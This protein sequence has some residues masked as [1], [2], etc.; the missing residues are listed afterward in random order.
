M[1]PA[2]R[3]VVTNSGAETGGMNGSR[4]NKFRKG[5]LSRRLWTVRE[6]EILIG[7]LLELVAGGWKSDN[8]FRSGYL[9]RI[10]DNIRK[11]FPKTDI[12][13]TPHVVSKI[14]AWKKSYGS[15]REILS[16]SGV[17]FNVDGEYKIDIEDD[18]WAQVVAA[19]RKARFMRNKSWPY[20]EAWKCIFGKD[21]ACGGGAEYVDIA[22]ETVRAQMASGSRCNENDYHPSFEDF[23]PDEVP[24]VAP[25]VET[26]NSSSAH[27]EQAVS[28]PPSSIHKRKST[29]SDDV[30]MEFLGNLHAQTNSR[31]DIISSRIG[32]EFDLGKARQDVFDKLGTV[33]GLTLDQR[34]D[35]CDIL[36]DKPQRLEVFMGMPANARL[37]YVLRLIHQDR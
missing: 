25:G 37:G 20:W 3:P 13:G 21:R 29:Q 1:S 31:L 24:I 22:T 14:T 6:E 7:S 15:L 12:K 18:Q 19:D 28:T 5:D 8:G 9:G 10:E 32:Y 11:E 30:L 27:T 17:G 34:Y 36:G 16:R 2:K 33:D 23:I 26:V 35:L 4:A